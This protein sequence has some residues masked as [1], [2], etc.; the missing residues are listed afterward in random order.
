MKRK[1]K[2]NKSIFVVGLILIIIIILLIWWPFSKSSVENLNSTNNSLINL[3][4]TVDSLTIK[5]S[6]PEILEEIIEPSIASKII[7]SSDMCED[8]VLT[9]GDTVKVSTYSVKVNNIGS[10]AIRLSVDGKE[11]VLGEGDFERINDLGVEIRNG[12]IA[13]FASDDPYNSVE[14]RIGCDK[15][16]DPKDKYVRDKGLAVCKALIKTVEEKCVS[17]FDLDKDTFD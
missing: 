8:Y 14:L 12:K 13:Y 17:S 5:S 1:N 7:E 3:N 4:S 9:E 6:A 16:E 15:N 2:S 10:A 11:G